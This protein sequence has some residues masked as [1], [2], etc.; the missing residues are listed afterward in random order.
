[1]ICSDLIS[2]CKLVNVT[3]W[4]K[5]CWDN[6]KKFMS[7]EWEPRKLLFKRQYRNTKRVYISCQ[8]TQYHGELFSIPWCCVP[9]QLMGEKRVTFILLHYIH[10][11]KRNNYWYPFTEGW[12]NVSPWYCVAFPTLQAGATCDYANKVRDQK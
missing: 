11:I 1:M 6:N 7:D 3:L 2:K 4:A 12:D 10:Y 8:E 9:W 5:S